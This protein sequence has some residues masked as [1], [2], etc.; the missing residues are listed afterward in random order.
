MSVEMETRAREIGICPNC[1]DS[2]WF[3]P[4][5]LG[6]CSCPAGDTVRA[7]LTTPAASDVAPDVVDRLVK[8]GGRMHLRPRE[9]RPLMHAAAAALTT[10]AAE[11]DAAR[12]MLLATG[13][14][15]A[16]HLYRATA[17]ETALATAN[18][19][20]EACG[21]T[22]HELVDALE[23]A[24]TAEAERDALKIERDKYAVAL[25]RMNELFPIHIRRAAVPMGGEEGRG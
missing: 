8:A 4:A 23:R 6:P 12:T 20:M 2:G 5:R 22:A 1:N 14:A 18:A 17:A 13:E 21:K 15:C 16:A 10:L 19:E 7:T 3:W 24:T 9:L 25:G 11:R